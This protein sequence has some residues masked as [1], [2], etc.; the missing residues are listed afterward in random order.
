MCLF[1]LWPQAPR[2]RGHKAPLSPPCTSLCGFSD[3]LENQQG[4]LGGGCPL[5]LTLFLSGYVVFR[6]D[7]SEPQSP[8]QY[9]GSRRSPEVLSFN[10]PRFQANWGH[11]P[12]NK[13]EERRM[14][15]MSSNPSGDPNRFFQH[16]LSA[17][18]VLASVWGLEL[19]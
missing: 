4:D 6:P 16:L 2:G 1:L 11:S 15:F 3:Y 17:H 13:E 7:F 18:C 12:E 9:N 10:H 19:R 5:A 14:P 8:H